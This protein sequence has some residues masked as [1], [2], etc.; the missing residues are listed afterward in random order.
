[1]LIKVRTE[2]LP[3]GGRRFRMAEMSSVVPKKRIVLRVGEPAGIS[4]DHGC[5]AG[6]GSTRNARQL[7]LPKLLLRWRHSDAAALSNFLG[8]ANYVRVAA[9]AAVYHCR[10]HGQ[11]ATRV[12]RQRT[13]QVLAI[14]V[15]SFRYSGTA[16]VNTFPFGILRHAK[17]SMVWLYVVCCTCA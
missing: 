16:M 3:S 4:I 7:F 17:G 6:S 10:G 11:G 8:S 14:T 13:P 1:M 12:M 15:T 5:P 2:F 9:R